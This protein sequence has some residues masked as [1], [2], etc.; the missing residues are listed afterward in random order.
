MKQHPLCTRKKLKNIV[1]HIEKTYKIV[2]TRLFSSIIHCIM[3]IT[4]FTK[5]QSHNW[6]HVAINTDIGKQQNIILVY[7]HSIQIVISTFSLIWLNLFNVFSLSLKYAKVFLII[8][9]HSVFTVK[10]SIEDKMYTIIH[11]LRSYLSSLYMYTTKFD[12]ILHAYMTC[13]YTAL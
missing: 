5:T 2:K 11:R 12:T 4:A 9:I 1:V 7:R 3:I 10:K 6:I 8:Y 13:N